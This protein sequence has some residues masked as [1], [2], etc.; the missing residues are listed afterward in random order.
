VKIGKQKGG[1]DPSASVD[2]L[3][4][5]VLCAGTE[6]KHGRESRVQ[7]SMA[8]Q[9]KTHLRMTAEPG[10]QFIVAAGAGAGDGEMGALVQ[11]LCVL[12]SSGQKGSRWWFVGSSATRSVARSDPALRPARD[13]HH[14][15]L[16]RGGFQTVQGSVVTGT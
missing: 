14:Y 8:S 16:A 11:G 6:L 2:E 9:K 10:A 15:D 13:P 7:G 5:Q 4:C 12:S 3:V 1:Q